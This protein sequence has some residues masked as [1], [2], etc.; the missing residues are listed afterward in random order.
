MVARRLFHVWVGFFCGGLAFSLVYFLGS[1]I[2]SLIRG[3][4]GDSP[5]SLFGYLP[6]YAMITSVAL[7]LALAA[8]VWRSRKYVAL[9]LLLFSFFSLVLCL[10]WGSPNPPTRKQAT[11]HEAKQKQK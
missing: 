9:G 5:T 2:D 11:H 10:T 4:A 6:G 3:A 1:L 8:V 7:P